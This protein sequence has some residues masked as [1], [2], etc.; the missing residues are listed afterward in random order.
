MWFY[1]NFEWE[2]LLNGKFNSTSNK[3]SFGILLVD[4]SPR[5]TRNTWKNM[6]LVSTSHFSCIFYFLSNVVHQKYAE[7]VLFGCVIEFPIQRVLP[8]EIW[9]K[10]HGDNLKIYVEKI[11]LFT[12]LPFY[13]FTQKNGDS[14][15]IVD[16]I[17]WILLVLIKLNF[18]LRPIFYLKTFLML[19]SNNLL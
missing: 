6:M 9:I 7:W 4:P 16:I 8:L 11:V 1:S 3:Y 13:I 19:S 14:F 12:Y 2:H 10:S 5:K 17:T 18:V 15:P